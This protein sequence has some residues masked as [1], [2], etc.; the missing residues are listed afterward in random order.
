MKARVVKYIFSPD[1]ISTNLP[2][3]ASKGA[4]SLSEC[5]TGCYQPA[6]QDKLDHKLQSRE[7]NT[8]G[9]KKDTSVSVKTEISFQEWM[10]KP[11]VIAGILT[12]LLGMLLVGFQELYQE[13]PS[14]PKKF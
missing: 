7:G 3:S 8:G 5:Q 13:V 10:D 2:S 6:S 12:C 9:S 11:W 1:S 14:F 4:S